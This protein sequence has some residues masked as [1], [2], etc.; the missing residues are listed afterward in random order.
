MSWLFVESIRIQQKLCTLIVRVIWARYRTG[1]STHFMFH[2]F[3]PFSLNIINI[4]VIHVIFSLM[5]LVYLSFFRVIYIIIKFFVFYRFCF[6]KPLC[7]LDTLVTDRCNY[8]ISKMY[9]IKTNCHSD[10]QSDIYRFADAGF[11]ALI[12]EN[13]NRHLDFLLW[14]HLL[15]HLKFYE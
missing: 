14:L 9:Q 8:S 2:S 3:L 10:R 6:N 4:I 15:V 7:Y 11:I 1:E 12:R 5:T 13:S